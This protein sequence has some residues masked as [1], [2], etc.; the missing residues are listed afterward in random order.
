[1]DG[2]ALFIFIKLV[3]FRVTPVMVEVRIHSHWV[4]IICHIASDRRCP[5]FTALT[6]RG[7]PCGGP[8]FDGYIYYCAYFT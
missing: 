8:T 7:A 1:M 6:N 3:G 5:D 2:C 4:I